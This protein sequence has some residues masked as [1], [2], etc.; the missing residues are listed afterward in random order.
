M[1][2]FTAVN[3]EENVPGSQVVRQRFG[4]GTVRLFRDVE[5]RGDAV[6]H[7][8]RIRERCQF[9]EPYSVGVLLQ[10]IGRHLEGQARLATTPRSGEG[11]EPG[12][13]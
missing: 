5:G 12:S 8:C 3:E 7:E 2:M 1:E 4:H 6:W 9:D 11:K 10:E 13:F